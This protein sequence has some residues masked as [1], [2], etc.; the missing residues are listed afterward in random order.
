MLA[1]IPMDVRCMCSDRGTPIIL[2]T[3]GNKNINSTE[4]SNT[5]NSTKNQQ[6]KITTENEAVQQI[7]KVADDSAKQKRGLEGMNLE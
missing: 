5:N 4:E 2:I 6:V 3:E 7:N 1:Q